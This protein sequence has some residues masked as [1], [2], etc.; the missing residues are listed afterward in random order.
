MM[1]PISLV[2]G[3]VAGS[4][5]VAALRR[6]R[7]HRTEPAG[8][9]DLLNWA[10]LV[11]DGVVLQKDGALLAGF[12]YRGPDLVSAT[13]AELDALAR[14]LNDAL[15]PYA[16]GWMFHVD[17]I[18]HPAAPYRA[19]VFPSAVASTGPAITGTPARSA[20]AWHSSALR[21]PPP[22]MLMDARVVPARADA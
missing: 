13:G 7:E 6:T 15:L 19:D 14:Q 18:R 3:G 21:A 1:D 17:A 22:T 12:R 10:F 16:D 8:L 9:A 20:V 2:L 5:V 4:G 11:A